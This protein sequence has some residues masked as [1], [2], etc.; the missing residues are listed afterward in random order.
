[1]TWSPSRIVWIAVAVGVL[2]RVGHLIFLLVEDPLLVQPVIDAAAYH[3]W[4]LEILVDP[5]GDSVFFQSPAYPYA[6]GF[7]YFFVGASWIAVGVFQ[8]LLGGGKVRLA[9]NCILV[10]EAKTTT[11]ARG[12]AR[13]W[14][15]A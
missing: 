2:L 11:V 8:A 10:Y 9:Q 4:A 3:E 6:V 14:R 7:I 1:M 5:V 13:R 12:G 15:S